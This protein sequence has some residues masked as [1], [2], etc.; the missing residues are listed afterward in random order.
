MIKS[1][2]IKF[3]RLWTS[4]HDAC[5]P[6]FAIRKSK[7]RSF[8]EILPGA[9]LVLICAAFV[10]PVAFG[11][12]YHKIQIAND[13]DDGYYNGDDGSGWHYVPQTGGA[14]L[15]GSESSMA[16]AWVIGYRFESTGINSGDT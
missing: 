5:V 13:Q 15:V 3:H 14:D 2:L 6:N 1:L 9:C 4:V 16:T 12:T 8:F 11:Q 10:A 7:S